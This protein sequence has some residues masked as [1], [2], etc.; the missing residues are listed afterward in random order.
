VTTCKPCMILSS[1]EGTGTERYKWKNLMVSKMTWL[2]VSE[3]ETAVGVKGRA[4]RETW[5]HAEI[6][7][8]H[9]SR[10][11]MN[12]DATTNQ[13]KWCLVEVEGPLEKF[14]CANPWI[15]HGLTEKIE[16]KFSLWKKKVSKVRWKCGVNAGQYCQEVALECA[17]SAFSPVSA[18]HIWWDKLEFC[19]PLEGDGFFVCRAGFIVEN[20]EVYQ[21]TPGCK[22]CHNG[23]VGCNA[24]AVAL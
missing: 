1:M 14:P 3:L 4:N 18:M 8:L 17:N 6:P 13:T 19:V 7:R 15:E 2:L 10:L 21:K 23:I 20:L 16:G 12:E 24:M 9:C 11:C 22:A 5:F